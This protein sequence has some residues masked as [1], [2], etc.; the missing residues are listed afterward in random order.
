MDIEPHKLSP[1]RTPRLAPAT[2]IA[3]AAWRAQTLRLGLR[4]ANGLRRSRSAMGCDDLCA[5]RRHHGLRRPLM[6][7]DPEGEHG[8]VPEGP[9]GKLQVGA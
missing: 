3:V 2:W 9:R 8:G 5:L 4:R 6:R 7:A 1:R